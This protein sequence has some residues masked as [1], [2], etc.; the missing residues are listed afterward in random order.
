MI[1]KGLFTSNTP[2]WATPQKLFDDLDAEFHFTLDP[3]STHEN[4]KCEKHYTYE[5]DGLSQNWGGIWFFAIH[6]MAENCLSGSRNA[7][8]KQCLIMLQL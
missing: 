7:M 4:A 8:M 5:D 3:C 1:T 6:H 2:E